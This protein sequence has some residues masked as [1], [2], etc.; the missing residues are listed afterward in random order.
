LLATFSLEHSNKCSHL[1]IFLVTFHTPLRV[2]GEEQFFIQFAEFLFRQK[3]C[4]TLIYPSRTFS[5]PLLGIIYPLVYSLISGFRIILTSVTSGH[6]SRIIIHSTES[7]YAGFAGLLASK[8]L[9]R[10]LIVHVHGPRAHTFALLLSKEHCLPKQVI[11]LFRKY[12]QI[13][14]KIVFKN[15]SIIIAVSTTVKHYILSLGIPAS[16]IVV[17]PPVGINLISFNFS[18][19]E[20]EKVKDEFKIPYKNLII[21]Y[22]GRLDSCKGL[23]TLIRAFSSLEKRNNLPHLTLLIVGGGDKKEKGRLERLVK[24][25]GGSS[26]IFT[27]FRDDVPRI[28]SIIDIFT[29]P[30]L[31]EGCPIALLEAMAAG[32]AIVATNISAIRELVRNNSEALLFEP[33]SISGLEDALFRLCIDQSLRRKIGINAVKVARQYDSNSIFNTIRCLYSA[34]LRDNQ[35]KND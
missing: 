19:Q 9:R 10:P 8:I 34:L 31:S 18:A 4:F 16:K 7:G 32:K 21:G 5:I 22:V 28:L 35:V 24:D 3:I 13:L 17:N 1:R 25:N 26:V 6:K 33:S 14:D 23:D 29:L 27:G 2:G 20:S 15:A 12:H 30:S 11:F